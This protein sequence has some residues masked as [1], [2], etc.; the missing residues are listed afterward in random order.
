[1]ISRDSSETPEHPVVF[2]DDAKE[3]G[4]TYAPQGNHEN[5][6]NH[7]FQACCI[8]SVVVDRQGAVSEIHIIVGSGFERS[9]ESTLDTR[10]EV[11]KSV[12]AIPDSVRQKGGAPL[13]R[14]I[15]I[16]R[17]AALIIPRGPGEWSS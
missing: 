3:Q 7:M 10:L 13:A 5:Q 1:M 14:T 4:P 6:P 8:D 9:M 17:E 15:R 11:Q 2:V 16:Y 12:S